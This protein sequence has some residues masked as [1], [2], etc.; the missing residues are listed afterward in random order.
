MSQHAQLTV[1]EI[2][3]P[4]MQLLTNLQGKEGRAWLD[5]LNKMLRKENPWMDGPQWS[6]LP[7]TLIKKRT[8]ILLN[9]DVRLA[10]L[11]RTV[12]NQHDDEHVIQF[13]LGFMK[14]PEEGQSLEPFVLEFDL[15]LDWS[16]LYGAIDEKDVLH[17][18]CFADPQWLELIGLRLL[19]LPT[20]RYLTIALALLLEDAEL[21]MTEEWTGSLIDKKITLCLTLGAFGPSKEFAIVSQGDDLWKY[22][23]LHDDEEDFEE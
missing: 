20:E 2:R 19:G 5:A 3:G 7:A 10:L 4:Y 6:A 16:A 22:L 9:K 18:M 15:D 12:K 21:D 13:A 1:N 23:V 17:R 14:T 11:F 8:N